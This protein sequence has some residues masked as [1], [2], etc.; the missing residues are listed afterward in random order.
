MYCKVHGEFLDRFINCPACD[1]A[2]A[3]PAEP[4]VDQKALV[5]KLVERDRAV[6]ERLAEPKREGLK[7]LVEVSE[8]A[9]AYEVP[10][11]PKVLEPGDELTFRDR[12]GAVLH[13]T[14]REPAETVRVEHS[15][16]RP[17]DYRVEVGGR[18]L[19]VTPAEARALLE[20]LKKVL[21]E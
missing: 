12:K 17:N 18:G 19:L 15:M 5:D 9:G 8:E 13:V 14:R 2:P 4:K 16:T 20:Q 1:I 10:A 7:K 21:G 11:E 6:F 3:K